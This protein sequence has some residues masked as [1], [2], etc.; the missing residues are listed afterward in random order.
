VERFVMIARLKPQGRDRAL[1]LIA[2]HQTTDYAST[3]FERVAIFLAEGEVVFVLEGVDAEQTARDILNDPVK[4]T[5]IGHWLP[6]FDGPLHLAM[7]AYH[8]ERG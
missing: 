5:V 6:L 4:S 2:D 7:E 8:W 3:S 1:E